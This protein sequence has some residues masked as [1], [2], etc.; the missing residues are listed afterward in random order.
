MWLFHGSNIIT[1]TEKQKLRIRYERPSI[2]F[3][4]TDGDEAS[5]GAA[6]PC[7]W[8]VQVPPDRRWDR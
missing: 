1:D 3:I 2:T 4:V 8:R 5:C 6:Q 7:V